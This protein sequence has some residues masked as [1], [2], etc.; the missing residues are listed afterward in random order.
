MHRSTRGWRSCFRPAAVAAAVDVIRQTHDAL[1]APERGSGARRTFVFFGHMLDTWKNGP[2]PFSGDCAAGVAAAIDHYLD[3]AR[4][5]AT[6]LGLSRRRSDVRRSVCKSRNG[7]GTAAADG[8]DGFRLALHLRRG[9]RVAAP[10][11]GW[12]RRCRNS[13][14]A[15]VARRCGST[16]WLLSA[17]AATSTPEQPIEGLG[18][19]SDSPEDTCSNC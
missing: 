4:A 2:T 16:R 7:G 6:A 15:P 3:E 10:S 11:A 12:A 5:D 14:G 1:P 19:D 18:R 13:N 9:R 17:W 8:R